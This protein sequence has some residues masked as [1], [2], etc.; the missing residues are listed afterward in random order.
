M[1]LELVTTAQLIDELRRRYRMIV[2]AASTELDG[3]R[4]LDLLSYQGPMLSVLGL[5]NVLHVDV[6]EQ[7]RGGLEDATDRP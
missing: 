1:N 5:L 7:Y 4:G 2:V 3:E 6:I